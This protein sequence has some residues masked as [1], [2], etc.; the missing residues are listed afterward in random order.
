MSVKKGY[1]CGLY[2]RTSGTFASPTHTELDLVGD[3]AIDDPNEALEADTRRAQGVREYE[4]GR[5]DVVIT[6]RVRKDGTDPA[7]AA[8]AAAK[9][10]RTELDV[11]VLDGKQTVNGSE[12]YRL[13]MKVFKLSEDQAQG[14][15]IYKEFELRPC[16]SDNPKQTVAVSGGVP[17]FTDIVAS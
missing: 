7:Y 14:V 13:P 9:A 10:G 16:P 11:M 12:G 5:M 2:L 6:G 17:V 15:V 4:P 3:M 1:L 8:L